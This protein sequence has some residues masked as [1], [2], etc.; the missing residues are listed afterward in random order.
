M[1]MFQTKQRSLVSSITTYAAPHSSVSLKSKSPY[2]E[3]KEHVRRLV[4]TFWYPPGTECFTMPHA[5]LYPLNPLVCYRVRV[6]I[7]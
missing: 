1:I 5:D 6:I 4:L 2:R 7:L 3:G